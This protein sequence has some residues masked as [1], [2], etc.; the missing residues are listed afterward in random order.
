MFTLSIA[1]IPK[2]FGP[3]E[4]IIH[5]DDLDCDGDE[6]DIFNCSYTHDNNC[7]HDEDIGVVCGITP[8]CKDGEMQLA[9]SNDPNQGRVEVCSFGVWGTVCDDFWDATDATVV[10]KQLGLEYTGNVLLTY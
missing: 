9:G 8:E 2:S 4:G 10:C 1:A 6:G 5:L 3:G 7:D